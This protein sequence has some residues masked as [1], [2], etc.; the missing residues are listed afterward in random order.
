MN[1]IYTTNRTFLPQTAVGIT[2]VCENNRQAGQIQFFVFFLQLTAED[3]D[4][5]TAHVQSYGDDQHCR[6]IIWIDLM[7]MHRWFDFPFNTSGWNP[8][9]LARLLMGQLLPPDVHRV[10]YMDGDTMV[11][12]SLSG[13][14]H[15]DLGGC[16]LGACME[17]T[18][19]R[20]RRAKLG[21]MGKPYYNAGVLLVDMDMWREQG[22][23]EEIISFYRENGGRLFANDQDA[24][25]GYLKDRIFPLPVTYNYHNTY[26]IYRYRFFEKFCD[27]PVPSQQELD[28]I[29]KDPCV[30]HF[31]GEERPWREGNEHR[32]RD[33]YLY[34]LSLTPW[35]GEGMEKGWSLYFLCW[36][37]FNQVMRPFPV[38]RCRIINQLIPLLL[39]IRQQQ[40]K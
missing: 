32:F 31:L 38:L 26:D 1:I 17:P 20:E 28:Q 19:S 12:K 5:L 34:Y 14:W 11:R 7:D 29:R 2:S 22:V 25:N 9:V 23:G 10:L 18:C 40:V 8:I 24:I 39:R 16:V 6:K 3:R 33:E 13:L 4:K 15:T 35:R 36:R 27:Y 21:L 37:V 30:V